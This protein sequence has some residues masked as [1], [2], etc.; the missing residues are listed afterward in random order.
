MKQTKNPET[1]YGTLVGHCGVDSGQIMLSDP[2]YVKQFVDEMENGKEFS[3]ELTKP[4]PYTYN[5][6]C[7]ATIQDNAGE[8][9]GGLGVVVTS[10]YGD[11]SYPVFVTYTSDGRPATATIVFVSDEENDEDEDEY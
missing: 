10:G 7:S 4:F 3:S 5:G 8:L 1:K 6:A 2:C 9:G 11:G